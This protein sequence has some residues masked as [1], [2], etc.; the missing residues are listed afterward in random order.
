MQGRI[1]DFKLG[2]AYL[3]KLRRAEGGAKIFGVFRVKNH[4][5][6][7]KNHI[8]SNCEGRRENVWGISC[9]KSRFYAKI[10]FF[11]I[12][13]GARA[14]CTPLRIRPWYVP[15]VNTSR[16]FP[17]SWLITGI[18]I[19][20]TRRVPLVEQELLTLPEHLSSPPIFS[21]V[22]VTRSLFLCVCFVDRCLSFCSF[23]FGHCVVCSSSIYAGFWLS[24]QLQWYLQTLLTKEKFFS[25]PISGVIGFKPII[26]SQM[27]Y[28]VEVGKFCSCFTMK[29]W[30]LWD[31][32][33]T[34][35]LNTPTVITPTLITPTIITPTLSTSTVTDSLC[36]SGAFSNPNAVRDCPFNL[37][38][39]WFLSRSRK[40]FSYAALLFLK[41]FS[42]A[43]QNIFYKRK[44][45]FM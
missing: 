39:V 20:L 1:Q 41:L 12:L 21:G 34:P 37:K 18:V 2:G 29:C 22:R 11:P 38:G 24:L 10:F 13:G 8:F 31:N 23:S 4:D 5:F 40:F 26:I 42:A 44:Y 19:R 25:L 30:S 16:S 6:T 35:T 14:G 3:K 9:E 45:Y 33:I 28:L 32:V 7:P 15:L 36:N 17:N 27:S 43:H